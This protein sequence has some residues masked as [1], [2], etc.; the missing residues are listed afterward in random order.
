MLH[1]GINGALDTCSYYHFLL[2]EYLSCHNRFTDFW[3]KAMETVRNPKFGFEPVQ[4]IAWLHNALD[5]ATNQTI[6]DLPQKLAVIHQ[7]QQQ[8][9]DL[10]SETRREKKSSTPQYRARSA[11]PVTTHSETLHGVDKR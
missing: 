3:E 11:S 5:C 2:L 9:D 4:L 6:D 8:L 1:S 7:I 10:L